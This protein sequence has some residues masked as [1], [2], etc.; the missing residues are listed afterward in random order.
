MI[1]KNFKEDATHHSPEDGKA[2]KLFILVM[3]LLSVVW[4]LEIVIAV[5]F[6]EFPPALA[7]PTGFSI[8][9]FIF[10]AASFFR[11]F[12]AK[13]SVYLKPSLTKSASIDIIGTVVVLLLFPAVL[14][15]QI[16]YTNISAFSINSA[17]NQILLVLSFWYLSIKA[18]QNHIKLFIQPI[19]LALFLLNVLS[20]SRTIVGQTLLII[21]ISAY[22]AK[23]A[24]S[25]R[26]FAITISFGFLLL[27]I[28]GHLRTVLLFG[29][30]ENLLAYLSLE[31]YNTPIPILGTLLATLGIVGQSSLIAHRVFPTQSNFLGLQPIL[32]D[33]FGWLPG[34]QESFSNL[35]IDMFRYDGIAV[36]T[37]RPGGVYAAFYMA[38]GFLGVALG[39]AAVALIWLMLLRLTRSG[40]VF[41]ISALYI[42][43][44]S[45]LVGA[46]GSGFIGSASVLAM[47]LSILFG[48]MKKKAPKFTGAGLENNVLSTK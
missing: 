42:Y 25:P 22:F 1:Q 45:I 10:F 13:S 48:T 20:G 37:S 30:Q 26:K 24:I 38:G 31:G 7:L 32:N 33:M 43:V 39:A 35:T 23:R 34:K 5:V 6:K 14:N 36:A 2:G 47:M 40:N 16:R 21:M 8:L 28:L 29:G 44:S 15:A 4:A 9:V 18:A 12:G 11:I 46:Y 17:T 3:S 41:Y 19:P 27:I